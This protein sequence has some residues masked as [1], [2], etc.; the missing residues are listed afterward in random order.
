LFSRSKVLNTDSKPRNSLSLAY[1]KLEKLASAKELIRTP[2]LVQT[3]AQSGEL[4]LVKASEKRKIHSSLER[5]EKVDA[6]ATKH[7]QSPSF[8][9]DR[10]ATS[11]AKDSKQILGW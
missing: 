10:Q 5:Q 4:P 2:E 1:R 6:V 3:R 9:L 7:R 8:F 11:W